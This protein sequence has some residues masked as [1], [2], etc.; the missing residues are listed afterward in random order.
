[1][2]EQ[3][4]RSQQILYPLLFSTSKP[5]PSLTLSVVLLI[6]STGT[7]LTDHFLMS[8]LRCA[9][10]ISSQL[11]LWGRGDDVDKCTYNQLAVK[12]IF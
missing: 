2:E 9:G 4:A 11:C 1:M 8:K 3:P 10:P 7:W 6:Q 5:V 12:L